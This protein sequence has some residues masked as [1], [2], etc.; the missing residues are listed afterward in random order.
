MPARLC[1]ATRV[2]GGLYWESHPNWGPVPSSIPISLAAEAMR[3]RMNLLVLDPPVEI[4]VEAIGLQA[5]G[6]KMI[7]RNGVY[8]L[9]DW[10][11]ENHYPNVADFVEE[12]LQLGVSRRV[13]A[14]LP[15]ERLTDESRLLLVH[16]KAWLEGRGYMNLDGARRCP[17]SRADHSGDNGM[18]EMCVRLWWNDLVEATSNAAGIGIR[19]LP[20]GTYSGRVRTGGLPA[21]RPAIFASLKLGRFALVRDHENFTDDD[22]AASLSE[23]DILYRRVE[24]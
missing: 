22:A 1:G 23:R 9:L 3:Q 18:I 15:L 14:T 12:A 7:E 24:E 21:Q 16:K 6:M 10:V 17:M 19:T 8:H 11:G 4:D 5:V 13:A 20:T 2:A